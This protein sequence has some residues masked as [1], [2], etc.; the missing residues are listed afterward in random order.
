MAAISSWPAYGS[1][2]DCWPSHSSGS[3]NSALPRFLLSL[4]LFDYLLLHED[5]EL[6]AASIPVIIDSIRLSAGA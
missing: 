3:E 4:S 2:S 5:D 1:A 6:C